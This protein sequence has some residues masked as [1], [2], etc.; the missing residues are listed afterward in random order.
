MMRNS[1]KPK[2]YFVW[3]IQNSQERS[4]KAKNY[5]KRADI[6][7][8]ARQNR[9]D[10]FADYDI[11]IA[12]N[13]YNIGTP[14]DQ[15]VKYI[16]SGLQKK[17]DVFNYASSTG[18]SFD[19]KCIITSMDR[20]E[21]FP[22]LV[23]GDAPKELC[24]RFIDFSLQNDMSVEYDQEG[25]DA[26]YAPE[27]I[28]ISPLMNEFAKYFSYDVPASNVAPQ[29]YMETF[30][31]PIYECFSRHES[32]QQETLVDYVTNWAKAGQKDEKYYNKNEHKNPNNKYFKGY[33]SF[34]GAA[35]AK[36]L[37]IDDAPLKEHPDYPYELV[38]FKG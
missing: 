7:E 14:V 24:A 18:L 33:W 16:I 30:E 34:M 5:L 19:Q 26:D 13:L 11:D 4:E 17:V 1:Y 28:R 20:F 36:I 15:V 10:L 22:L 25:D 38:H 23:L 2:D 21:L 3:Q 35:V 31:A 12:I 27:P 32:H 8:Q 29:C 37:N 9:S 6:S